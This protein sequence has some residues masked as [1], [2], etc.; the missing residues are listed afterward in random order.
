M[1]DN[2][3]LVNPNDILAIAKELQHPMVWPHGHPD[4]IPRLLKLMALHSDKNHDY[5][6]GGPPLGN[7]ERV[8]K[9][10]QL[11]PE[12]PWDTPYG[13]ATVYMLKQFDAFMWQQRT[14]FAPKVE[15]VES[16]L[17]DIT[18][19]SQLIA[20]ALQETQGATSPHAGHRYAASSRDPL[21]LTCL[22]CGN[23]REG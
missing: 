11:Y 9:I 17:G 16:R 20:I 18:V 6:I 22:D 12:F 1:P 21:A 15:G 13:V 2:V 7:F 14:G 23:S 3:P 4:F 8:A 19:Y 5:A 10:M